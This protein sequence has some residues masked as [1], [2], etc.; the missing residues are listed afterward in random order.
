[1]VYKV[2]VTATDSKGEAVTL[3]WGRGKKR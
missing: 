2:E 1:M 3:N